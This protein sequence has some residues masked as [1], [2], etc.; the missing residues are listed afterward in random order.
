MFFFT[1]VTH[2]RR[3]LFLKPKARERLQQAILEEKAVNQ[4]RSQNGAESI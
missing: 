1:L 3:H 2:R 4:G